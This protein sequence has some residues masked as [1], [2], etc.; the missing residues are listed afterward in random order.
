MNKIWYYI[1]TISILLLL[2]SGPDKILSEI[3]LASE[4]TVANCIQLFSIYAVWLGLM[5]IVERTGLSN[6]L[7]NLLSPIIN[8]LFKTKNK[9]A[10]K[11]IAMNISANMLG[12]GNA[13]TPS[14]LKAMSS[15]DD[16]S[17][18]PV[19]AMVLLVVVNALAIEIIPSTTI[20]LRAAN[21]SVNASDIIIPTLIATICSTL[22]GIILTLMIEKI[23]RGKKK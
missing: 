12:L 18:K 1:I 7:A 20:S 8:K 21:G 9:D 16:K 15:L 5:E 13:S 22:T 11:Y 23:K 10:Q 14:A 4:N 3:L 17:G 6:K 19:F 2:F